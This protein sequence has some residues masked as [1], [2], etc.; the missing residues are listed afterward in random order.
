MPFATYNNSALASSGYEARGI[1]RYDSTSSDDDDDD[2]ADYQSLSSSEALNNITSSPS[3]YTNPNPQGCFDLPF[4]TPKPKRPEA[5]YPLAKDDPQYI[6]DFQFRQ[7]G[8]INRIFLNRTSWAP[9]TTDATLWQA[10]DQK[11]DVTSGAD[12][13]SGGAYHN[14]DFRLDQQVLLVPE[15]SSSVQVALNSLDVMEHPFHMHGMFN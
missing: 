15:G 8:E 12:G 14:W 7:V 4:D 6:I 3:I 1:L 10:L 2:D 9:Y 5:A 13:G 11:F